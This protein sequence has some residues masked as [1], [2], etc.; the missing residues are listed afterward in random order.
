[1]AVYAYA[2]AILQ[3]LGTV[4]T[5]M[6]VTF[7]QF[8]SKP[9][10]MQYPDEKWSMPRNFRG[11]IACDTDACIACGL[12]VKACPVGCITVDGVK[13]PGLPWK[14]C[15]VFVVDNQTCMVCGLC[16]DPCP[17]QAI[18]HSHLY[19]TSQYDR[20]GCTINWKERT[21]RNP[22]AAEKV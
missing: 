13:E 17:T 3:D 8:V 7:R 21:I 16:V 9:V 6:K 11:M 10:T 4:L 5:G 12:C 22:A 15:T 20:A 19:E 18:F 1:M 2:R 14:M